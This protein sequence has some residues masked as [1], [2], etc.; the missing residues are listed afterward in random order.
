MRKIAIGCD[1]GGF[2]LKEV[3]KR[4]LEEKGFEVIDVGCYTTASVDYPEY[5]KKVARA[6]TGGEAEKGICI[7]STG[8]GISPRR[9]DRIIGV[10]K[11]YSTRVGEGPFITELNDAVGED[12]RTRGGEYGATTGRPRRCGWLDLPVVHQAV[13]IN[14]LTDI[15]LTKIDILTGYDQIPVCVGYDIEGT[16]RETIPASLHEYAKAKP[17]YKYLPGWK[18]DISGCRS[19]EELPVN[20]QN[21]VKFIEEYCG[22]AVSLVSVSP[23][24][25]ANIIRRSLI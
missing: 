6:V 2:P 25:D 22:T 16:Y 3:V 5:G 18:E 17:V 11:A 15:A 13:V 9:L 19:F 24:R 7:C 12:M 21:Y 23:D 10:V 1:H 20:C 4:H 14:G 8:I